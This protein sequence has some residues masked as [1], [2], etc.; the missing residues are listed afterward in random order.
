MTAQQTRVMDF[1]KQNGS[2]T[3][4]DAV[5]NL[6]IMDLPKRICELRDAGVKFNKKRETSKNR[7]GESVTYMRYSFAEVQ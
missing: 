1:I 7:Y 5:L 3:S 4:L 6:G 2:I